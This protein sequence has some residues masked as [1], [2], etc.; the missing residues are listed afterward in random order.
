ML[1]GI[2]DADMTTVSQTGGSKIAGSQGE[3]PEDRELKTDRSSVGYMKFRGRRHSA[4]RP[5]QPRA[6]ETL[7][8]RGVN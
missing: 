6:T 2:I 3:V 5:S 7:M 1:T 8:S 4:I